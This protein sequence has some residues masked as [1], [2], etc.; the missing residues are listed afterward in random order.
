MLIEASVSS[1]NEEEESNCYALR[2][3]QKWLTSLPAGRQVQIFSSTMPYSIASSKD[4]VNL[5]H[6]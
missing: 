5:P 2:E 1:E 3:A 4:L 6:F